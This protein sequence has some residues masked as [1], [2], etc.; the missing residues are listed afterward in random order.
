MNGPNKTES[1]I[2]G[3]NE[4]LGTPGRR[5]R[6]FAAWL[7]P[8][9]LLVVLLALSG[10]GSDEQGSGGFE[11][12]TAAGDSGQGETRTVEH[13]LGS[14]E[15]PAEP[16]RIVA[17]D[18]LTPAYLA[19]LEIPSVGACT[20]GFVPAPL[21]SYYEGVEQFPGC[22]TAIP[23]EGIIALEP[24]LIVG[25]D[26]QVLPVDSNAYER[27]SEIAPTVILVLDEDRIE[28]L[29]DYGR[30]F[31]RTEEARNII[32]EFYANLAGLELE[33][34]FSMVALFSEGTFDLFQDNFVLVE[35]LGRTGMQQAT[36]TTQLD[37]YSSD[38]NRIRQL[39]LERAPELLS[40][41][42]L[43][44]AVATTG[45]LQKEVDA[46]IGGSQLWQQLPAVQ[47]GNVAPISAT[48]AFGGAG[49]SGYRIAIE[50]ITATVN[51]SGTTTLEETVSQ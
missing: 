36:D 32:D 15:I 19:E 41:D 1:R 25:L 11:E 8:A 14:T 22:Q 24:D 6:S 50:R 33:G 34:T 46:K 5:S 9:L 21:E 38:D 20:E 10:C 44:P 17:V 27:L 28:L 2:D 29:A 18:S 37:G 12:T 7:V 43:I 51:P 13:A 45:S 39:S 4:V 49:L 35:L 47:D 42:Y 40:G 16:Q 23:Y 26:D 48:N 30:V 31:D 3:Q